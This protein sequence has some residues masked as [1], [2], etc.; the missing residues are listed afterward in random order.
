MDVKLI[1]NAL[2]PQINEVANH[3]LQSREW[4]D[5][6]ARM[7]KTVVRFG[8]FDGGTLVRSFLMTLHSIPHTPYSL[9]YIQRSLL[10]NAAELSFLQDYGRK[11]RLIFIKLEPDTNADQS[12]RDAVAALR[13]EFP[14]VRSPHQLFPD[15]TMELDISP[16][17]DKL[18]ASFKQKTRYN[19]RLAQKKGV[20]VREATGLDA[21]AQFSKLYFAT[22]ARQK[23]YGHDET[24]HRIVWETL[25]PSI[26]SILLAEHEGTP[27]AAYEL[28]RF[29]NTLYYPYGGSSDEKRNLMGANAIM[30]EAIRFGKRHGCTK[31]DMWG[32]S[33][34][35]A[36]DDDPYSGFTKFKAGYGARFVEKIG[37]WDLVIHKV[38]YLLYSKAYVARTQYLRFLLGLYYVMV[39]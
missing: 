38:G 26:A 15:W 27:L 39:F 25:S 8:S 36:R 18:L 7:G 21:F 10:P 13:T 4:G 31:F 6:R 37:S 12:A 24:Y 30:W 19:I 16:S 3:P 5:A 33:A 2:L 28:F 22:T 35:D 17:E 29:K 9:G 23:Y 32:S 1:P 34:P 14:L 20:T 11:N